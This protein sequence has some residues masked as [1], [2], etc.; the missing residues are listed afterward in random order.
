[1]TKLNQLCN[2]ECHS[3]KEAICVLCVGACCDPLRL[4]QATDY[5]KLKLMGQNE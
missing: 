1:M 5:I 3:I 4:Q 2:C